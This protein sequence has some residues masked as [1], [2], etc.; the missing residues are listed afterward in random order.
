M[1]Y[2]NKIN[3]KNVFQLLDFQ[4]EMKKGDRKNFEND[5][6]KIK[7]ESDNFRRLYADEMNQCLNGLQNCMGSNINMIEDICS[8]FHNIGNHWSKLESHIS[9]K[10]KEGVDEINMLH[11]YKE[12]L[13]KDIAPY[14]PQL[15]LS[16][17]LDEN[18]LGLVRTHSD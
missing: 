9:E 5:H 15:I 12:Y 10:F 3:S 2:Y 6:K 1:F 18:S 4:A 13:E 7:E 17:E 14:N 11:A 16:D 8:K